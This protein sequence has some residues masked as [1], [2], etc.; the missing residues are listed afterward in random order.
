MLEWANYTALYH[1]NLQE[2]TVT[3]TKKSKR[4]EMGGSIGDSSVRLGYDIRDIWMAGYSDEQINAVTLG[5]YALNELWEKETAR[6]R[7]HA[8]ETGN[9]GEETQVL[10][11]VPAP[12]RITPAGEIASDWRRFFCLQNLRNHV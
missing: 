6:Q 8:F 3:D 10:T 5:E 2:Y 4:W 7:P 12:N 11:N 9:F 1:V